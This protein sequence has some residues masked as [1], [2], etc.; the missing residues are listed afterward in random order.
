MYEEKYFTKLLGIHGFSDKLLTTHFKLYSGYVK[1]TNKSLELLKSLEQGTPQWAEIK[2]RFGWEFNGMRLHELYFEN[3]TKEKTR[4][5]ENTPLFKAMLKTF[6]SGQAC[7]D[8]FMNT[9]KL[10][11]IGWVLMIYDS[12]G[13]KILNV[14]INEHDLGHLAG[15]VPLLVIDVFEHAFVTDYNMERSAYIESFMKSIDWNIVQAR[16]EKTTQ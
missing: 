14:W 8:D 12:V 5:S 15:A 7:H 6:G 10:R 3:M 2:R 4:L 1:N 9:A 16:F 11:G 13:E